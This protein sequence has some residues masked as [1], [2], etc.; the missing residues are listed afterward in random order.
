[1]SQL[2]QNMGM[3][4]AFDEDKADFTKLGTSTAGNIFISQV[5]HKTYL[6]L[7]E[8]GTKAGAATAVLATDEAAAE[9][10]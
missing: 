6:A 4:A 8:N 10:P 7:D 2:L 1:M 3:T 9:E 5:L